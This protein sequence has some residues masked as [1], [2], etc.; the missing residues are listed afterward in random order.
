MMMSSENLVETDFSLLML[1]DNGFPEIIRRT[2]LLDNAIHP[3]D[4]LDSSA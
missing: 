4:P 1:L 3:R 2:Y